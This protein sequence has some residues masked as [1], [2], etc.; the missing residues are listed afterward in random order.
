MD[1]YKENGTLQSL[2]QELMEQSENK[3]EV[4]CMANECMFTRYLNKRN[5]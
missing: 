3:D 5:M 1:D 2:S 4:A